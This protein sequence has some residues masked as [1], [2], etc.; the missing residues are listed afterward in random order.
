M[1][2]CLQYGSLLAHRLSV[3]GLSLQRAHFILHDS[4]FTI[5]EICVH[6]AMSEQF[7]CIYGQYFRHESCNR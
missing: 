6:F 7:T 4:C 1:K 2:H 5:K 3:G